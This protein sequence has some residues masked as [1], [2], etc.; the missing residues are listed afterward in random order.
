M[1]RVSPYC[2]FVEGGAIRCT[3]C[4][5]ECVIREG[6]FGACRTRE[7][8]GGR[9][10]VTTHGEAQA[11]AVDPIEKKP[12]NHFMPGSTTFSFASAGCNLVCPFCQNHT[13]SQQL[14]KGGVGRRSEAWTAQAIVDAAEVRG[15]GSIS[16]TYSEPILSIELAADVRAISRPRGIPVV[17][18]T[19]GQILPGPASD[20]AGIVSA[21]NVDLKCFDGALYRDVLGG[22][23]DATLNTISL[24]HGAGVWVEVTT[25]VIPGFNDDDAQL[26][27]IAD[28][29]VGIDPSIPWHVSRFHPDHLWTDRGPT[30]RESLARAFEL[31]V[32]AGLDHVYTGNVPGHEGEKTRCAKCRA[33]LVDRIGF[34]TGTIATREGRCPV[35]HEPVAGIGFP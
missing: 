32:E 3:L 30:P 21:A 5:H 27:G 12:L 25:L 4:P 16:F 28:F 14:R 18:V 35:C 26:R 34:G 7:N 24:L 31:G 29:L 13:L 19:N 11:V 17:F 10:V 1:D 9:L 20:L 8:R 2:V 33:L 15:C 22:S 6:R 23:L